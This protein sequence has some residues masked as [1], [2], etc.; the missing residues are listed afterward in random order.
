MPAARLPPRQKVIFA[1]VT[2]LDLMTKND[3]ATHRPVDGYHLRPGGTY[4][5]CW[6]T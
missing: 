3:H 1:N 6:C 4:D 2:P 5:M